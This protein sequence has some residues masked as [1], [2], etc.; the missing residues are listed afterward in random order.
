LTTNR[1]EMASQT[2]P[3]CNTNARSP[4]TLAVLARKTAPSFR[5]GETLL[6]RDVTLRCFDVRVEFRGLDED[7]AQQT[8]APNGVKSVNAFRERD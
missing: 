8:C 6:L 7:P 4:K 2:Q 5:V 3:G 1:T